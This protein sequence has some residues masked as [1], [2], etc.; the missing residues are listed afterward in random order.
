MKKL[1]TTRESLTG[2]HAGAG[3][4]ADALE[5]VGAIAKLVDRC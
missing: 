1:M 5:T 2:G 3:R 4:A